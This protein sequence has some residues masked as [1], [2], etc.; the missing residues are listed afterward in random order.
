MLV[1][2]HQ[3]IAK[4]L[5]LTLAILCI[6]SPQNSPRQLAIAKGFAKANSVIRV[7]TLEIH[8]NIY[9]QFTIIIY[10]QAISLARASGLSACATRS[11]VNYIFLA[12]YSSYLF[13]HVAVEQVLLSHLISL[14]L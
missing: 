9:I 11:Q 7:I 1:K 14:Y 5:L 8:R 12:V 10:K 3:N 6:L 2:I 13:V 4:F